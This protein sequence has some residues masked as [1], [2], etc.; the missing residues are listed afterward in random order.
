[1]K[2]KSYTSSFS[3]RKLVPVSQESS[4]QTTHLLLGFNEI[5]ELYCYEFMGWD[6][7]LLLNIS[8]SNIS[9]IADYIFFNLN[10][11]RELDI[12]NNAVVKL[13]VHV[14]QGLVYGELETAMYKSLF[15]NKLQNDSESSDTFINKAVLTVA[16]Y[17]RT[18]YYK[19]NR[20]P[21]FYHLLS[22]K[23]IPNIGLFQHFV[24]IS[25]INCFSLFI[26]LLIFGDLF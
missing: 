11:L 22:Q 21:V 25:S 12:S 24:W 4:S 8:H 9:K 17:T 15:Q 26:C 3:Q 1:M 6:G 16:S 2:G 20:I 7:L 18:V 23:Q 14:F 5:K 13:P 19:W 10:Q